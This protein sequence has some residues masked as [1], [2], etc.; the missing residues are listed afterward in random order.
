[1]AEGVGDEGLAV[2]AVGG[3]E[4]FVAG[5]FLVGDGGIEFAGGDLFGGG[6]DEAELAGGEVNLSIVAGGAHGWAKGAAE[7]GAVFI[8]IAGAVVEVEDGAGLVV[9]ELF[10]EDGGFMIFV[11][12]AGGAVAWEP[13]I[14]AGERVG[15]ALVDARCSG[16]VGLVEGGEA[17]AEARCILVGDG[18]DSDAALG[19]AG[20]ADEMLAAAAVGVGHSGIYDLDEIGVGRHGVRPWGEAEL[21]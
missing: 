9:G 2:K 7:D 15:Y 13:G 6:V 19:A 18:E 20:F 12:D 14:E 8:E 1:L 5:F 11:K 3:V 4:D 17:F 16:W 10:E 21:A